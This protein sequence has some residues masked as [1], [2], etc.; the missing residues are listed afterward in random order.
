MQLGFQPDT[1]MRAYPHTLAVQLAI[2]GLSPIAT[3][4]DLAADSRFRGVVIA[5]LTP[6]SLLPERAGDQQGWVDYYHQRYTVDARV[7]RQFRTLVQESLALANPLYSLLELARAACGGYTLPRP[8]YLTTRRDRSRQADYA[9][10]RVTEQRERH[11]ATLRADLAR[12]R[13]PAPAEWLQSAL[14]NEVHIAAIENRGGRV[15]YVHFP[16]EAELLAIYEEHLPRTA[17]WDRLAARTRAVVVDC[18]DVPELRR[19]HCAD[20]S[21]M[22][23]QVAREFTLALARDLVERGVLSP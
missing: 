5:A 23:E 21:H 15:V 17:Y 9:L 7:N 18:R 16:A 19:F 2:D 10:T 20:A 8:Y 1:F 22:D 13:V 4:A 3:L 12:E 11:L 6:Q 14:A